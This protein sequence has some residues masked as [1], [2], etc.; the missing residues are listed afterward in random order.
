M[1]WQRH[2]PGHQP[3]FLLVTLEVDSFF[4]SGAGRESP[5]DLLR[6][7]GLPLTPHCILTF[8]SPHTLGPLDRPM[9][10]S[11]SVRE[12]CPGAAVICCRTAP[13]GHSLN[14]V[15]CQLG[16]SERGGNQSFTHLPCVRCREGRPANPAPMTWSWSGAGGSQSW[17]SRALPLTST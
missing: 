14:E 11:G 17:L 6:G 2:F 3:R 4:G 8:P 5:V 16:S 1:S 15:G 10:A 7:W 12:P 9:A 13:G